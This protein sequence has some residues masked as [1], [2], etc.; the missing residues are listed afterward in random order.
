MSKQVIATIVG[1]MA[2]VGT[3]FAMSDR[4]ISTATFIE[5]KDH[6]VYRLDA[7]DGKLDRILEETN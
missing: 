4:Y 2:I 3:V 1:I 5:F 6:I 7:I